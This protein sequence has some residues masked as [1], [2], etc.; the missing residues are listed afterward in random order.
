MEPIRYV[1]RKDEPNR[2]AWK[3]M[4][5][6]S[7]AQIQQGTLGKV[8]LARKTTLLLEKT[9]DPFRITA[10]LAQKAEGAA[11]FCLEMEQGTLLGAS[12]E[13]LFCREGKTITVEA[14]AGTRRKGTP[15]SEKDHREFGFVQRYLN[16]STICDSW[17]F[18]PLRMHQTTNV[19]HLS[20]QG[21]GQLRH[22]ISDLE[23]LTSLHPTPALSG[24]PSK[25]AFDWIQS[26][27]P[28]K[29][30]FYGGS[31]LW[32]TEQEADSIV[33][34]RSCFLQGNMAILYVGAGIVAGSKEEA[35]WEELDAKL[36]LYHGVYTARRKV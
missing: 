26:A 8:V 7:L 23:I 5:E 12:P 11:L 19:Q 10:H 25:A 35:E 4:V 2:E 24:T 21:S 32:S 15:F 22:G 30:G 3:Q 17:T 6:K 18:S 33:C 28:F 1:E 13:R 20:S 34:I 36:S 31:I 29:R 9:P 16:A 27:E 14:L